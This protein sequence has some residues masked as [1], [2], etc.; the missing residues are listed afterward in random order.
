V[1]L[2]ASSVKGQ[3]R[4][5][6]V[7][8][9]FGSSGSFVACAVGP[10]VTDV[11]GYQRIYLDLPGTGESPPCA[12]SS[13]AVLA[14][15]VER[16]RTELGREPFALMGFSYGGYL[17]A[18][19]ARRMPGQV[20][21]LLL[22]CSGVKIRPD[23]RDLSDVSPSDPEPGWLDSVTTD[24]HEHL[25]HAVGVQT[26]AVAQRLVEAFNANGPTEDSFLTELQAHYELSGEASASQ[27]DLPVRVIAGRRD[28]V[29]GFKDQFNACVGSPNSDYILLGSAGHYLPF[30]EPGQFR[31]LTLNW[32]EA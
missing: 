29:A 23:Q 14:E 25:T 26:G 10:A 7:L 5:I 27:L 16:V 9:W 18:A 17:A 11:P 31:A 13:D 1:G 8:P 12:A 21:R 19:L 24:L 22:V 6:V 2:V 3:G 4:P 32:L 15:V 30:E 20:S 28:R